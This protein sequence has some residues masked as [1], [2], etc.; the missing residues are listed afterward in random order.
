MRASA[1][2]RRPLE[3]V[4]FC[5]SLALRAFGPRDGPPDHFVRAKRE[6]GLTLLR[7]QNT[8]R[9]FEWLLNK[10]CYRRVGDHADAQR[11][12]D[13]RAPGERRLEP[14]L[15]FPIPHRQRL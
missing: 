12:Q 14:V 13:Q 15:P 1:S 10:N 6:P 11:P 8:A 4:A 2:M 7:S 5:A 3:P 9:W